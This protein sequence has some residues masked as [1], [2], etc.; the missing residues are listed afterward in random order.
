MNEQEFINNLVRD[1]ILNGGIVIFEYDDIRSSY[2]LDGDKA[3]Y[4]STGYKSGDLGYW[5]YIT[6]T[7][8]FNEYLERVIKRANLDYIKQ[9]GKVTITPSILDRR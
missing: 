5:F 4:L 2:W 6:D 9:N 1:A 3:F 8:R 7:Y